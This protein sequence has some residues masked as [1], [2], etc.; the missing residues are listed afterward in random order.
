MGCTPER[1][2]NHIFRVT[3][4]LCS[5]RFWP[6]STQNYKQT[7]FRL[8]FIPPHVVFDKVN[9]TLLAPSNHLHS[10]NFEEYNFLEFRKQV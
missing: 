3:G 4:W 10:S 6:R 9:R 1:V 2:L 7:L 8:I 5:Q